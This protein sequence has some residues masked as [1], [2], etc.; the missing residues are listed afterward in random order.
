MRSSVSLRPLDRGAAAAPVERHRVGLGDQVHP[1]ADPL[2]VEVE[3]VAA[4][5]RADPGE[6]GVDRGAVVALLVVLDDHLPV[7][8]ELVG[9]ARHGDQVLGP[10]AAD[11]LLHPGDVLLE[12]TAVRGRV[13]EEPAVPVDDRDREQPELALVEALEVA[14][15]T[16]RVAQA[17]VQLVA[18]RRGTGRRC[19]A[20]SRWCRRAAARGRGAG[21]CS[22]TPAARRPRRAPAARRRRRSRRTSGRRWRPGRSAVPTHCQ[23][24]KMFACSQ[25]E[26]AGSRYAAGGSI[27]E[28]PNS[29]YDLATSASGSGANVPRS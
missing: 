14:E 10:V 17:A 20:G 25:S 16:G 29:A 7:R 6:L 24:E 2:A 4:L 19:C 13:D 12:R 11:D 8:R 1:A 26:T 15:A 27:R 18:T 23:P 9:V 22:R 5:R 28:V 3:V 21:R